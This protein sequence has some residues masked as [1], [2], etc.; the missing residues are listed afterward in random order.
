MNESEQLQLVT[1]AEL[2]CDLHTFVETRKEAFLLK[3]KHLLRHPTHLGVAR[4]GVVELE[5]VPEDLRP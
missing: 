3:W 1:C 5:A 2:G 4:Y